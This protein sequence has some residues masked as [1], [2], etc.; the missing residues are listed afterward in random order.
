VWSLATGEKLVTATLPPSIGSLSLQPSASR[1]DGLLALQWDSR[2]TNDSS[3]GS[4]LG[5]LDP[6]T[7]RFREVYETRAADGLGPISIGGWLS[8]TLAIGRVVLEESLYLPA[9]GPSRTVGVPALIDLD[10]GTVAPIAEFLQTLLGKG[11]GPVPISVSTGPFARIRGAGGCLDVRSEPSTDAPV[12]GCYAGR[13]LL[14]LRE[15]TSEG[16]LP[17]T[18]PD[19]REGW[20]AAYYLEAVR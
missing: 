20:A 3:A 15:G 4:F 6:A 18:T 17:V 2:R 7:A 12:L 1:G 5:F 13:V 10:R 16:W 11:G 19:G 14:P 8:P 9:R